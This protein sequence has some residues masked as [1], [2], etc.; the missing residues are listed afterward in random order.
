MDDPI[1]LNHKYSVIGWG[2]LFLWWGIVVLVNPLTIGMGAIGSGLI[3]F[4]VN[5]ARSSAGVW[6]EVTRRS[7]AIIGTIAIGWGILDTIRRFLGWDAGAS[8][9]CFLLVVGIVLFGSMLFP[10]GRRVDPRP[11]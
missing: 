8:F 7:N 1:A 9:A 2:S 11:Q 4:G 10:W 3:L 6:N 5:V